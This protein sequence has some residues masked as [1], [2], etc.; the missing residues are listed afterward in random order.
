MA[1][2][3]GWMPGCACVNPD[4]KMGGYLATRHLRRRGEKEAGQKVEFPAPLP[5]AKLAVQALRSP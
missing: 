4:N 2:V 1:L 5:L 3:D